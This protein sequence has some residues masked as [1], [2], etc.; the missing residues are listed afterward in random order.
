MITQ[1]A[2]DVAAYLPDG[3]HDNSGHS[4]WVNSAMLRILGIDR[5]TPDLSENLSYF[6]RDET[7]EPTGLAQGVRPDALHWVTG[8]CRIPMN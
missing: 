1:A 7:G 6:V 2:W 4:F 5:N 8:W 3:P